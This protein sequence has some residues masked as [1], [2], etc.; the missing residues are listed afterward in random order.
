MTTSCYL[1]VFYC[2]LVKSF[3]LVRFFWN[4]LL[5]NF[6]DCFIVQLSMFF[7]VAFLKCNF[8]SLTHLISFVN[9]FFNLFFQAL[10]NSLLFCDSHIRLSHLYVL[11]NS[12]LIYF[13]MFFYIIKR[14]KRD[15]NPRAALATYTLS[16]GT[17][18]ASWV[19]LRIK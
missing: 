16:R 1:P 17:S 10:S 6:R 11:V 7:V 4:S 8:L 14:R 13:I 2:F 9:N 12:F 18:S 3:D 5:K 19:F 15:L